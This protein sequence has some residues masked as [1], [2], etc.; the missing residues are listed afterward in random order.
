ELIGPAWRVSALADRTGVR[1]D[2][3][4]RAPA[5]GLEV[6]SMGLPVG[7]IQVPPDG[8]PIVMLAD[9]PV[10]GGYPVPAV[11]IGADVGRVARLRTGDELRFAS[12]W[13]EEALDARR[14]AEAALASLAPLG[15]M[16]DDLGWAGS[17]A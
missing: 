6:P 4:A 12:A 8:R 7:A 1:L 3:P 2:G 17:H 16:D 14:Q 15:P 10:T 5:V 11:V 9:R 13:P